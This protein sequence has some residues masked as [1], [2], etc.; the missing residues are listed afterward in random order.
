MNCAKN[1]VAVLELQ[2]LKC[3]WH[4]PCFRKVCPHLDES[5]PCFRFGAVRI[6]VWVHVSHSEQIS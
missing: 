1:D 2:S 3:E 5:G 4:I 6:K